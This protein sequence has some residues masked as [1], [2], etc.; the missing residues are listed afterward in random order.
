MPIWMHMIDGTEAFSL[1]QEATIG[2]FL[3]RPFDLEV[4]ASP[5][6]VLSAVTADRIVH[7]HIQR[8]ADGVHGARFWDRIGVARGC[9]SVVGSTSVSGLSKAWVTP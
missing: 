3:V 7:K 8:G 5:K 1:L 6:H 4:R 2:S 9:Y